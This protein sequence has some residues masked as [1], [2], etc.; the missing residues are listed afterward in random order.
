MQTVRG[1]G[2]ADMKFELF[3]ILKD[4]ERQTNNHD[5]FTR[6][7]H[8]LTQQDAMKLWTELNGEPANE[9]HLKRG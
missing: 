1:K 2:A 6:K 7:L 9:L 5:E 4:L 8:A 3:E